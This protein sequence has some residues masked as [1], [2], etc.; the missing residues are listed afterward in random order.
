MR[1]FPVAKHLALGGGNAHDCG[2][3]RGLFLNGFH[4]FWCSDPAFVEGPSNGRVVPRGLL[5]G[6]Q[7]KGLT[8][9]K[10]NQVRGSGGRQR[11]ER[12][13][14]SLWPDDDGHVAVVL[15]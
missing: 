5:E 12:L 9:V 13:G 11:F 3:S 10:S 14:V 15:R 1:I 8:Q 2:Q 4:G 7:G 6:F